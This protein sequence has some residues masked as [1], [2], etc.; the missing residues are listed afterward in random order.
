MHEITYL[1]DSWEVYQALE[2]NKKVYWLSPKGK[3]QIIKDDP[4]GV[5]I[6]GFIGT[7]SKIY[8]IFTE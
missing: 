1:E 5:F 3:I 2:N 4:I 6:C 7:K 8:G